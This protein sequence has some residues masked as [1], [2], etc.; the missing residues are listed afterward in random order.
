MIY[1]NIPRCI[2]YLLRS[3]GEQSTVIIKPFDWT[4]TTDYK[5]SLISGKENIKFKVVNLTISCNSCLIKPAKQLIILYTFMLLLF[6]Q[7]S[8]I[9]CFKVV[10]T[11]EKIDIEL[12]KKKEKIY[13][14]EDVILF[15]DELADNG[16]ALLNVKMVYTR[17]YH[18]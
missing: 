4:F 18:R 16:C 12:L 10:E 2:F 3:D 14:F 1:Y 13:F 15:E 6:Y 5:G 9:F 7:T 17:R 11:N 8:F